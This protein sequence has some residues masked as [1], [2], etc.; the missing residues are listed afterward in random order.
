MCK[1]KLKGASQVLKFQVGKVKFEIEPSHYNYEITAKD[2]LE[3]VREENCDNE[4]FD[5]YTLLH[6]IID[7]V[8]VAKAHK[9]DEAEGYLE[10]LRAKAINLEWKAWAHEHAGELQAVRQKVAAQEAIDAE[11]YAEAE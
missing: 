7:P 5:G 11:L 1:T 4:I 10:E 8:K 3:L 2:L 6:T 9:R